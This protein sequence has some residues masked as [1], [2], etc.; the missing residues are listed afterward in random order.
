MAQEESLHRQVLM[1]QSLQ[2]HCQRAQEV[3]Q[4]KV[5]ACLEVS[6]DV[7]VLSEALTV[8]SQISKKQSQISALLEDRMV[9]NLANVVLK[10]RDLHLGPFKGKL[11][12]E[13]ISDLRSADFSSSLLFADV[14]STKAPVVS[15]QRKELNMQQMAESE[16]KFLKSMSQSLNKFSRLVDLTLKGKEKQSFPG[17][18]RARGRARGQQSQGRGQARTRDSGDRQG[19]YRPPSQPSDRQ[20]AGGR[21][22]RARGSGRGRG[23]GR[24]FSP[25]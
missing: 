17:R 9:V 15:A 24:G 13:T 23:R 1:L 2:T 11:D 25:L 19:D 7:S 3:I 20:P 12:S 8:L 16:P 5:S 18:P 14:P 22:G 10:R 6:D 4:A 21:G